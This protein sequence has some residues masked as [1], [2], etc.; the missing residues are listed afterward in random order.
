MSSQKA[1]GPTIVYDC[2]VQGIKHGECRR[3]VNHVPEAE[4]QSDV[5]L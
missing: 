1:Y 2:E 3:R 5:S 4:C